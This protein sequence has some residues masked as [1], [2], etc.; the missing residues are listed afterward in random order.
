MFSVVITTY[1]AADQL[2]VTL[3]ALEG[4]TDDIIVVDSMSQD[5]T[6]LVCASFQ[7]KLF[8]TE[9]LGY[10]ATKNFGADEAK[11]DWILS[12]D[13]DEVVS[14]E[15]RE[16]LINWMPKEK[17]VYSLDRINLLGKKWIKHSGW[18]PDWKIRLYPKNFI[19]WDLAEVHEKLIIPEDYIIEKLRGKLYHHSYPNVDDHFTKMDHYASLAARKYLQS[20]K[21]FNFIHALGSAAFR[22]IKSYILKLGILDGKEGWLIAKGNARMMFLRYQHLKQLKESKL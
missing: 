9:W 21:D 14:N 11:Y 18:Y 5:N 1:N 4:L 3:S 22:F 19:K 12:I 7:V 17:H 20:G 6:A 13:T 10:G 8:Q 16:S 15:L 2:Q